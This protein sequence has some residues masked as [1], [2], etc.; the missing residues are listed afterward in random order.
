MD[1]RKVEVQGNEYGKQD[2]SKKHK[3]R[4]RHV[5]TVEGDKSLKDTGGLAG[6]RRKRT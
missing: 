6:D 5:E 2:D 3:R 1:K 4:K